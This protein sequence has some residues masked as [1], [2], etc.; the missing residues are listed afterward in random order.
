MIMPYYSMFFTPSSLFARSGEECKFCNMFAWTKKKEYHI[1]IML[2]SSPI[3]HQANFP[4]ED[5]TDANAEVLCLLLSSRELIRQGHSAAEAATKI[6]QLGHR[7][8]AGAVD[9]IFDNSSTIIA[10]NQGVSVYE[11]ISS[12]VTHPPQVED[13]TPLL[14]NAFGLEQQISPR[15]FDEYISEAGEVLV[16]AAPRTA[17]VVAETVTSHANRYAARV[18]VIGAAAARRFELDNM[19]RSQEEEAEEA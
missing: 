4:K 10:F 7:A 8:L 9:R 14:L 11:T 15:H 17:R 6:Y 16:L 5:L 18:A 19:L 2:L 3:E 1:C 12:L 13:M